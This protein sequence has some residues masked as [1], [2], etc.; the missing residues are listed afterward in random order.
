MIVFTLIAQLGNPHSDAWNSRFD[1]TSSP[2]ASLSLLS[3]GSLQ[4]FPPFISFSTTRNNLEL[5]FIPLHSNPWTSFPTL[6]GSDM[7]IKRRPTNNMADQRHRD[8]HRWRPTFPNKAY[9]VSLAHLVR[10]QRMSTLWLKVQTI[11][12]NMISRLVRHYLCD[13]LAQLNIVIRIIHT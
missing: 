3:F 7:A 1:P 6:V 9:W 11:H 13:T 8:H 4:T 2:R 12:S 10:H 5:S